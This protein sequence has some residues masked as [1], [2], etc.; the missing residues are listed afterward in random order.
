MLKSNVSMINPLIHLL[1]KISPH[2]NL[3]YKIFLAKPQI[4]VEKIFLLRDVDSLFYKSA[5]LESNLRWTK[6]LHDCDFILVPH[7]WKDIK[8]NFQYLSYL[9]ELS[10]LKP[11]VI[12]NLGDESSD[13]NL[14]NI[15]QLR[16]FTHP[17]Q[18]KNNTVIIPY[19][20]QN[21]DF[22]VRTWKKKPDI[23]FVG[24]NPR[25]SARTIFSFSIKSLSHP[26]KS[27]LY[28]NRNIGIKR[29]QGFSN[30]VNI[31]IKLNDSYSAQS[32]NKNSEQHIKIY[33]ENLVNTDYVFCPRGFGNGSMRFYEVLSA[34]RIPIILNTDGGFP[35]ISENKSITDYVLI[36]RYFSNWEKKI[37]NHWESIKYNYPDLQ[38]QNYTLFNNQL[39]INRFLETLFWP[40]FN[41]G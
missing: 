2:L 19:N 37:L 33:N 32:K 34:G 29:I 4:F 8:K 41:S 18:K 1:M 16:N 9:N 22:I 31:N 30:R 7:L 20:V 27:N 39:D 17:W 10:S 36:L 15:I 35:L 40:Y 3:N 14:Q 6:D 24:F 12:F 21:R 26:I 28:L 5:N 23:S 38:F 25:F 13:I 11:L